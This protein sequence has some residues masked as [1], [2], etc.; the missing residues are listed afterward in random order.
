MSVE[1]LDQ[2]INIRRAAHFEMGKT[3]PVYD[4][5][6]GALAA[7][8]DG[9]LI[10]KCKYLAAQI[11]LNPPSLVV[12]AGIG[13]SSM[14]SLAI[15]QAMLEQ[16]PGGLL[17]VKRPGN[18]ST[19]FICADTI[20]NDLSTAYLS[21]VE[22]ELAEKRRVLLIIVTKSGTT[23][24]TI[25]NGSLFLDCLKKHN[26]TT[27][28]EDVVIIT[29]AASPLEKIA[30]QEKFA[31][32][33][34]PKAVGG[35]FSVFTAVGLFP[36]ALMGIDIDSFCEGARGE[37]TSLLNLEMDSPR[38]D[39]A[40]MIADY[41]EKGFCIHDLFVFS[42]RLQMLAQWYKQLIGESLGKKDTVDGE[43]VHIGITPTISLGT[44]DLHSVVQLYLAG[45]RNRIT[46]FLAIRN[47]PET[48][49]VPENVLSSTL[50]GLQRSSITFTKHAIFQGV[51]AAYQK[52]GLPIHARAFDYKNVSDLGAYMLAKMVETIFLAAI[53]K[54][55]PFDQPAVE[56]Y[57]QETRAFLKQS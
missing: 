47:E 3:V 52:E 32:L 29:D 27:Y 10:Q 26:T 19:R 9:E 20:D 23:T 56:L 45:P 30:V 38:V 7:P 28:H 16:E 40:L 46:T 25:I 24:E 37:L 17:Y 13:G 15:L 8:Y 21:L 39:D 43:I 50:T 53:W 31:L 6:Y 55:N 57:K 1:I 14:G 34:I 41:Y 49:I 54:I 36:L 12:L 22:K 51:S 2:I 18:Q 42:P 33:T 35:R 11:N 48:V 4:T 44:S 5:P